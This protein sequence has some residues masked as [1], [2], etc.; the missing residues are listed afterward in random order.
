MPAYPHRV[1]ELAA[2]AGV[3]PVYL[4]RIF[5]Q[6]FHTTITV[7]LRHLRLRL[8]SDHLASSNR[9]LA[10][11]AYEMGFADQSHFGRV[12]KTTFQTTPGAFRALVRRFEH[13]EV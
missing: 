7:Y 13:A 6:H 9:S 4:A 2:D 11:I 10:D 1:E 5:K 12:F 8:A 3:H